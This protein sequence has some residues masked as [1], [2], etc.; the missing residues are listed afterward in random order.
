MIRILELKEADNLSLQECLKIQEATQGINV[1]S[2][3]YLQDLVV[4]PNGILFL[5]YDDDRIIG[6]AGA[7]ILTSG[8]DYY[9]GFQSGISTELSRSKV[10]SLS[11]VGILPSYQGKGLAQQMLQKRMDWLVSQGCDVLLGISWVSGQSHT[12]HRVFEK[13]GFKAISQIDDFFK[14]SSLKQNLI[15]PVCGTPPCLCP[16]IL[17]LKKIS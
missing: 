9:Q 11:I 17:Y 6:G 1:T 13:R 5:A 15:C 14:D 8:F 10:G 4:S 3:N 12:S 7:K 16:G 2:L